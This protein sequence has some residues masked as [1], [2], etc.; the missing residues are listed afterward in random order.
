[1]GITVGQP[2]VK[3]TNACTDDDFLE[4]IGD[5]EG[6][7]NDGDSVPVEHCEEALDLGAQAIA[8]TEDLQ[9]AEA[10]AEQAAL[11][12]QTALNSARASAKNRDDQ[13]KLGTTRVSARTEV[14]DMGWL[15][16]DP[17]QL[18]NTVAMTLMQKVAAI[19]RTELLTGAPVTVQLGQKTFDV[20]VQADASGMLSFSCQGQCIG[21][22]PAMMGATGGN[23]RTA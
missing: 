20:N 21:S 3:T 5:D 22:L 8:F 13:A 2:A 1:M 6:D 10:A 11:A 4:E 19:P 17:A 16:R 15:K 7:G 12:K 18:T 14:R 9:A 23:S